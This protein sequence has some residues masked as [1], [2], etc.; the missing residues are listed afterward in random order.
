MTVMMTVPFYRVALKETEIEAVVECLRSGWLTTGARSQEFEEKFAHGVGAKYAVAV[1][2]CTAALHLAL[3]AI[4]LKKGDQ[5]LL[6]TLTFAATAEVVRYFD[7]EPIFVDCDPTTL[8]MDLTQAAEKAQ[9]LSPSGRLKAIMPVHYGG[10]MMDIDVL[11]R[12]VEKYN[13]RHVH[14]AAHAL[15]AAYR[16]DASSPWQNVGSCGDIVCF[17]FYANKCITTGEGGMA[18]TN[19]ARWAD[20]MRVMSLHGIS[21]DAWK[22]FSEDGSW[23][24]EIVAP[25]YKYNL[26][27]IAAALGLKQLE[28]SNTL[29]EA[30]RHWAHVYLER[31][32]SC[33][34]FILPQENPNRRHSWHLFSVG[35]KE[36][37]WSLTR[38]EFINELKKRGVMASV[39]WMPL[40][41]QPYYKE[42]LHNADTDFPESNRRWKGLFSLPLFAD[43]REE[44][45]SQVVDACLQIWKEFGY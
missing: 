33:Q 4:G 15:P 5:V 8:C 17:S 43:L 32:K 24:Y 28:R 1:N 12:L 16:S 41:L 14:D 10:Q 7:A 19:N 36:N 39:H 21:K 18:V 11:S 25:G 44:E 31:L 30:R 26:T 13:L 34:G 22:R 35:L 40:H 6:P 3:E 23:Y 42:L 27:D 38:N 20:R 37:C 45:V 9:I 29:W 2:S